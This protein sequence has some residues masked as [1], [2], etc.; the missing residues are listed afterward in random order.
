[1]STFAIWN[2]TTNKITTTAPTAELIERAHTDKMFKRGPSEVICEF[3]DEMGL[4]ITNY[5]DYNPNILFE[6]FQRYI[7]TKGAPK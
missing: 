2:M 6:G 1:M 7:A 5:Q 3:P 4:T